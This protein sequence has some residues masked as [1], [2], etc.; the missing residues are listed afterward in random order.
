MGARNLSTKFHIEQN[1]NANATITAFSGCQ[2]TDFSKGLKLLAAVLIFFSG[3]LHFVVG[4]LSASNV[5]TLAVGVGFGIAYM[6]IGVGLFTAKRLFYYAG[7]ILPL[8]GA[9]GGTL[10]TVTTQST[11]P[12]IAVVIDV[13]VILCCAYILLHKEPQPAS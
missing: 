5:V 3:I 10:V 12:L 11:T 4:L 13:I 6:I 8:I 2:E 7:I 1:L 9:I